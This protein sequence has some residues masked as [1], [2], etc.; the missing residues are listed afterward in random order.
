MPRLLAALSL[1]SAATLAA[2]SPTFNWREVRA[3]PT[4]LKAMLP[5]KPDKGARTVPMAGREVSLE[6]LGCDTGGATFAVLFA[7]IGDAS[8]LGEVLAQWNTAT[9]LNLRS[10]A[11]QQR[12]FLPPG[13]LGLHQSLQVVARGKRADGSKVESHAAYFA[14]GSHVFQAVIYS[15]ELKPE[16]ADTFFSGLRL[17]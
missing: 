13:A 2:C 8:R 1:L 5:C 11:A 12:A 10:E 15:S 6:V 9:L 14:R 3:E 4:P 16:V 7:D 17:E